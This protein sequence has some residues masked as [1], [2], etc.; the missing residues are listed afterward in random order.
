MNF[1]PNSAR[2]SSFSRVILYAIRLKT[3]VRTVQRQWVNRLSLPQSAFNTPLCLTDSTAGPARSC[4]SRHDWIDKK[5]GRRL[6]STEDARFKYL[7]EDTPDHSGTSPFNMKVTTV[8]DEVIYAN[9]KSKVI[10][11]AGKDRS[12]IGLAGQHG[13]AYMHSTVTGRFI[14]SDYYMPDYPGWWKAFYEGKP[15]D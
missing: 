15:Q 10:A 5:T 14:T 12:A 11:I 8:G 9:G 13:T 1:F 7:D 2:G 4:L 3:G 6:Y